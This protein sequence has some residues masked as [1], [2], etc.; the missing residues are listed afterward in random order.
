MPR[1]DV[2][3]AGIIPPWRLLIEIVGN[4]HCQHGVEGKGGYYFLKLDEIILA[5]K[6][7]GITTT[8]LYIN[9]P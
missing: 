9:C 8:F 3:L 7:Y 6:E 5:K 1:G 4:V 2:W